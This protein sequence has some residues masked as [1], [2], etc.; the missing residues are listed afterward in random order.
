MLLY[1]RLQGCHFL[2]SIFIWQK[3]VDLDWPLRCLTRLAEAPVL[4]GLAG[5]DVFEGAVAK[6]VWCALLF[7]TVNIGRVK[8]LARGLAIKVFFQNFL[9]Q[10]LPVLFG[11]QGLITVIPLF[12]IF[13]E[14]RIKCD[15]N[16]LAHAL[17]IGQVKVLATIK[18]SCRRYNLVPC[19]AHFL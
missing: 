5:K 14:F 16:G 10:S 11:A 1:R 3:I 12:D 13:N 9:D 19:R 15:C 18:T 8:V 7:H 6:G 2:F 17:I 4:G